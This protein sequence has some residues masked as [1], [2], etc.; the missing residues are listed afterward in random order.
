MEHEGRRLTAA[1]ATAAIGSGAVGRHAVEGVA[2]DGIARGCQVHAYL[3]LPAGL[4]PGQDQARPRA[5]RACDGEPEYPRARGLARRRHAHAARVVAVSA[6]GAVQHMPALGKLATDDGQV[7]LGHAGR[8]RGLPA[9]SLDAPRLRGIAEAG[10]AASR[11]APTGGALAS[12]ISH[13]RVKRGLHP[14][15]L[16][17]QHDSRGLAVEPLHGLELRRRLGLPRRDQPLAHE[18]RERGRAR[19]VSM[20][21]DSG[22]LVD[23]NQPGVLEENMRVIKLFS[24]FARVGHLAANLPKGVAKKGRRT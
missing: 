13:Q 15:V 6:D 12:M 18:A 9:A 20:H 22:R 7:A 16:G 17:E 5:A 24:N 19:P 1:G 11:F 2:H 14:L 4:K 23:R 8:V 10:R 3:V 21:D